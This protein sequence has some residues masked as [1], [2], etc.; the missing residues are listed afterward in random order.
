[1][2]HD[3]PPPSG[4]SCFLAAA[5]AMRNILVCLEDFVSHLSVMCPTSTC[6][7]TTRQW[8]LSQSRSMEPARIPSRDFA[9]MSVF[10]SSSPTP[11]P[12]RPDQ[13]PVAPANHPKDRRLSAARVWTAGSNSPCSPPA[14]AADDAS[15]I[16]FQ[17]AKP[18]VNLRHA[19]ARRCPPKT[20]HRLDT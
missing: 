5:V 12:A 15:R 19:A 16:L 13:L 18:F 8:T 9:T 11:L 3:R 7:R 20:A 2:T 1:M 14:P 6:F 17:H 4:C 10:F